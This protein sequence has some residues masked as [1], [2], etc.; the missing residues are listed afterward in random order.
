[1]NM[2]NIRI[3]HG[4]DVH[5][6]EE[7]KPL[8]LCGVNI[9]YPYGLK[10]HSDGDVAIHSLCDALLGA[11]ALGDIGKF[12]PDNDNKYHNYASSKFLIAI[13]KMI[14]SNNYIINNIDLTIVAQKP[15]LAPFIKE[16]RLNLANVLNIK[17]N[18][19][20]VKATTTEKLGFEG[21]SEG[22]SCYAVVLLSGKL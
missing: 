2:A 1:M 3:G 5:K 6:F 21:R 19:V 15:K 7:N 18:Q 8:K 12:F 14:M 11:L 4:F 22:I 16:M 10:A 13:D 17:I 20:S 9:P